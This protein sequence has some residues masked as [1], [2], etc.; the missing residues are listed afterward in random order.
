MAAIFLIV[1]AILRSNLF[2]LLE[3]YEGPEFLAFEL[4]TYAFLSDIFVPGVIYSF[5]K[6]LRDFAKEELREVF[7]CTR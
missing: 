6:K 2:G 1:V 4:L 7:P 3:C 5:N